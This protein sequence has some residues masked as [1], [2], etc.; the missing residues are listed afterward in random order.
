MRQRY[1]HALDTALACLQDLKPQ[2]ILSDDL[3]FL[4]DS[5]CQFTY[6]T[7]HGSGA[8]TF[9]PHTEEFFEAIDIHVAGDD[10]R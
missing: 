8:R 10:V 5:A 1:A 7:G 9:G 3:A 2:A 4:W 6:E